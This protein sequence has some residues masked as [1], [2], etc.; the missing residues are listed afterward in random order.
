MTRTAQRAVVSRDTK[1]CLRAGANTLPRDTREV[2]LFHVP[3]RSRVNRAVITSVGPQQGTREAGTALSRPTSRDV[4]NVG[5]S[6]LRRWIPDLGLPCPDS[7]GLNP[8]ASRARRRSLS[9]PPCSGHESSGARVKAKRVVSSKSRIPRLSRGQGNASVSHG[10]FGVAVACDWPT[11]L[12]SVKQRGHSGW[13]VLP[14][15]GQPE[16][17]TSRSGESRV[18]AGRVSRTSR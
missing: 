5:Q 3:A 18:S 14:C 6:R 13:S 11:A 7:S 1:D 10:A 15:V 8:R 4:G 17:R 2:G 9:R 12:L 16:H